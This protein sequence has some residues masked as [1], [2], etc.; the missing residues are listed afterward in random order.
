MDTKGPEG[1]FEGWT[2]LFDLDGT[3]VDS[4]PDLLRALNHTIGTIGVAPVAL[5]DIRTMIGHGAK[6]MIRRALDRANRVQ[7]EA[8]IDALWTLFI[9]H[10]RANI[11]IDTRAFA[12]AETALHELAA[13]GARLAVCTNKTQALSQQVLDALGLSRHFHAVV[14]ADAVPRKKPD[15]DH[16]LRTLSAAG[17]DPSHAFMVGDSRTD[18]RA[19]R[20]A[21]LP[22][23]FVPFGYEAEPAE[24]MAA[25]AVVSS[26]SELIP[27]LSALKA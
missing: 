21:G 2:I 7:E 15:G 23:V 18:E 1:R 22:F 17:G 10:Y 11:A 4:A 12:G 19:A 9:E 27:V 24:A 8:Q 25:D 20:S 16:I 14:G 6:A 5:S 26:Y 13:E 3:L